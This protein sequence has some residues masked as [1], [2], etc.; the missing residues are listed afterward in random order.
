MV[1]N[2]KKN[3]KLNKVIIKVSLQLSFL[4]M[5][6]PPPDFL[7]DKAARE[8]FL[9]KIVDRLHVDLNPQSVVNP[10]HIL[11]RIYLVASDTANI[12][13]L[14]EKERINNG[15]SYYGVQIHIKKKSQIPRNRSSQLN[16][17][18]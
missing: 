16:L 9:K 4:I 8:E 11:V 10:R 1:L 13:F 3:K 6:T 12:Q 7:N 15:S 2:R 18:S 14:L 17:F 5:S